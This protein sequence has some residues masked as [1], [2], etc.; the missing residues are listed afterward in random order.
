[1]KIIFSSMVVFLVCMIMVFNKSMSDFPIVEDKEYADLV[2]PEVEEEH[3]L[4]K[5]ATID[6]TLPN[7]QVQK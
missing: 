7:L 6:G 5:L 2:L 1:M 4:Q 3:I